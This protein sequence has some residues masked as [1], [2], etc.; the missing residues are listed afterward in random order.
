MDNLIGIIDRLRQEDQEFAEWFDSFDTF[1]EAMRAY[2][3]SL[4]AM[5]RVKEYQ[6]VSASTTEVKDTGISSASVTQFD[7]IP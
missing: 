6:S 4:I 7:Y 5:G 3:E 1:Q 2:Q